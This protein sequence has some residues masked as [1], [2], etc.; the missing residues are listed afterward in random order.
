[1]NT[2]SRQGY[3][4]VNWLDSEF[5]YWA[6]SDVNEKELQEFQQLFEQQIASH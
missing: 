5:N 1:M 2:I 6:V 3:Y 4:L